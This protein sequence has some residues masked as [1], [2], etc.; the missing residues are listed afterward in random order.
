MYKYI[1][2]NRSPQP[3]S[4]RNIFETQATLRATPWVGVISMTN[5]ETMLDEKIPTGM[6]F[7][8]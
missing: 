6:I 1:K 2:S 7:S 5:K 3:R 4:N 8:F